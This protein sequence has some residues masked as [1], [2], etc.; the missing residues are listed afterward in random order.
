[1]FPNFHSD[2]YITLNI[3]S[4]NGPLLLWKDGPRAFL[5]SNPT[6]KRASGL[7][8]VSS[9]F[10]SIWAAIYPCF[11][12]PGAGVLVRMPM[13]LYVSFCFFFPS[14]ETGHSSFALSPLNSASTVLVIG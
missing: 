8:D 13:I 1:V 7:V 12:L 10:K 5:P 11:Y 6:A 2:K 3:L 14:I 9:G 4:T